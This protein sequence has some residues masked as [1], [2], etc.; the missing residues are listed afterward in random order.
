MTHENVELGSAKHGAVHIPIKL[1]CNAYPHQTL[2]VPLGLRLSHFAKDWTRVTQLHTLVPNHG[3]SQ[4]NM[5]AP[6]T[7]DTQ[8]RVTVHFYFML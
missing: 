5:E 3:Q 6:V 8:R 7:E 2:P 4:I 1:W